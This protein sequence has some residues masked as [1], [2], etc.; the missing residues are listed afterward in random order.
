MVAIQNYNHEDLENYEEKIKK[1]LEKIDESLLELINAKNDTYVAKENYNE[2]LKAW[3]IQYGRLKSYYKGFFNGDD[4]DY[5]EYFLDLG[6]SKKRLKPQSNDIEDI[7]LQNDKP[8]DEPQNN[9]PE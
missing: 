8:N 1:E 9:Q 3:E 2:A 6:K 5:K 7:E 4:Q